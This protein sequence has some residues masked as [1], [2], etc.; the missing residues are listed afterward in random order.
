MAA[1]AT[2]S[3]IRS[4]YRKLALKLHP[5]HHP[6]DEKIA[7]KFEAVCRAYAVLS[8][9]RQRAN[10]DRERAR[11]AP[12][13]ERTRRGARSE[14]PDVFGRTKPFQP[15]ASAGASAQS[16]RSRPGH[17]WARRARGGSAPPNPFTVQGGVF[18][19]T[20]YSPFMPEVKLWQKPL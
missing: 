15:K 17:S 7:K 18:F 1:T 13:P 3:E 2:L 16:Y 19:S 4:A 14:V 10:Y 11:P 12:R 5:D 8:D 9:D 6:K 20:G